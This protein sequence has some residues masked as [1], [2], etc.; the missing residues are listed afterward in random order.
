VLLGLGSF[1]ALLA[2]SILWLNHA[3]D[4]WYNYYVFQTA[5]GFGWSRAQA[6][7]F[8]TGDL[9]GACGIAVLVILAAWFAAPVVGTPLRSRRFCFYTLG[10]AGMVVFT[11]YLRAHRG[12]NVN[13]L[14]PMYA[15]VAVLFGLALGRLFAELESDNS[16]PSRAALA[17]LLLAAGVQLLVH[18]YS[19]GEFLPTR[20]EA[21]ERRAFE[22]QLRDIPGPVLVLSHPEDAALAGKPLFAG[23]ESIGAVIDARDRT[24]S[25]DLIAQYDALLHGRT[26]SAV[27]LD[28]TADDNLA[29]RAGGHRIWM[30]DDFLT[31]YPLR[32]R[33]NGG[34]DTRFTS[35]PRWIYLPCSQQALAQ[36]MDTLVD[37]TACKKPVTP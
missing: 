19:P 10:S 6:A 27:V 5:G 12:A 13:S 30:P 17:T 14:L 1:V 28:M 34:G 22:E 29:L 4:G 21:S 3:S 32:V 11:A 25:D 33:A 8:V 9:L 15:W 31:L 18:L 7:H 23:S 2:A 20:E 36:R 24:R 37:T 35:E 16:P 26:V